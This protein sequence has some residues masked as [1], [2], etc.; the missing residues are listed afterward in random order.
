MGASGRGPSCTAGEGSAGWHV[1]GVHATLVAHWCGLRRGAEELGGGAVGRAGDRDCKGG[2]VAPAGGRHHQHPSAVAAASACSGGWAHVHSSSGAGLRKAPRLCSSGRLQ[3]LR[4]LPGHADGDVAAVHAGAE[5]GAEGAGLAGQRHQVGRLAG[6]E[7]AV[8]GGRVGRLR[9]LG[10][11]RGRGAERGAG[12]VGRH[13]V[14]R[15][16]G[17]IEHQGGADEGVPVKRGGVGRR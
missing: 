14:A 13:A 11:D 12:D 9:R 10:R 5:V 4:H 8:V 3:L 17:A 2:R 16:R 15:D 1:T 7:A 6:R